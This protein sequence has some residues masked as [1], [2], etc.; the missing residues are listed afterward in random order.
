[1]KKLL[2]LTLTVLAFSCQTNIDTEGALVQEASLNGLYFIS[3]TTEGVKVSEDKRFNNKGYAHIDDN[4]ILSFQDFQLDFQYD[5]LI[6]ADSFAIAK[7]HLDDQALSK[8][9]SRTENKEKSRIALVLDNE[10]IHWFNPYKD[11]NPYLQICYCDYSKEEIQAI[12][13]KIN[14]IQQPTTE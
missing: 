2:L 5:S 1:M 11:V 7:F 6:Y 14:K 9:K 4:Q 12:E 13:E 8:W 10:L 3:K